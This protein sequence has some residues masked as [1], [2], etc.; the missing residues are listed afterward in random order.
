MDMNLIEKNLYLGNVYNAMR[1][2]D[3]RL[4]NIRHVLSLLNDTLDVHYPGITYKT[5]IVDDS[6]SANLIQ[7]FEECYQFIKN[8]LLR[9]EGVLVHCHGGISRSATTV[10]SQ[11]Q[12]NYLI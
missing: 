6:L 1:E 11:S 2:K 12:K 10:R 9:G 3:L 5:I 4:N 7:H 8:G